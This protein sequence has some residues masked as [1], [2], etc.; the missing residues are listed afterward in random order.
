MRHHFLCCLTCLVCLLKRAAAANSH[1][2]VDCDTGLRLHW[3]FHCA[4]ELVCYSRI[5]VS[6]ASV[7]LQTQ[8]GSIVSSHSY[9][10][11][12]FE[13]RCMSEILCSCL[14]LRF[15]LLISLMSF[16]SF[17]TICACRLSRR[18]WY[19]N[20]QQAARWRFS[21]LRRGMKNYCDGSFGRCFQPHCIRVF[22][23][24]ASACLLRLQ[25]C[26]Q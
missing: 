8:R 7:L 6:A 17:R 2:F 26:N 22:A 10:A 1:F 11:G 25:F 18:A 5:A 23:V 16:S 15:S 3:L 9:T 12:L 4:D 20:E 13:A 14:S 24:T 19:M 21:T